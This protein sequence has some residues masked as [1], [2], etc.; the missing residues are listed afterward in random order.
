MKTLVKNVVFGA[1]QPRPYEIRLGLL[2]GLRFEIDTRIDTQQLTGLYEREI[3]R[4][5][6]EFATRARTVIDIGAGDGYYTL[7]FASQPGIQKIIACEPQPDRVRL[8]ERNLGLNPRCG[9]ER[10]AVMP[11]CVGNTRAD[12]FV[13]LD[14]LL[15]NCPDPVLLKIDVE[16]AELDVLDSG[17]SSIV[18]HD[19]MLIVETH[20]AVLERKCI[21]YLSSIGYRC[22]VRNNGWYRKFVFPELRPL[23]HNRWFIAE[24]ADHV[25]S[26]HAA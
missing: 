19:V 4:S 16:G 17:R 3:A 14:S 8:L 5:V 1:T 2:S 15:K 6:R 23:P 26:H 7:F 12:K 24:R 21:D 11:V 25:V 20:S 9:R 13:N 10:I 18:N 22:E